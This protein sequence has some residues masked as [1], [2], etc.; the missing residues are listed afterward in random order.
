MTRPRLRRDDG[1]AGVAAWLVAVAVWLAAAALLVSP[2][3]AWAGGSVCVVN[4]ARGAGPGT[5]SQY[6]IGAIGELSPLSPATVAAGGEPYGVAVSPDGTSV[7]VTIASSNTVSQYTVD[8]LTGALSPKTPA[9][10]AAGSALTTPH[11]I[12]VSPSGTSV[13]VTNRAGDFMPGTVSQY[14]VDPLSGTLS[15]KTPS[16]VAAGEQPDGVAVS[17]DGKN[18]YVTNENE[19]TVSQYTV[20]P[21]TGTLSE[22]TPASIALTPGGTADENPRGI[23]V[24]PNGTSVYVATLGGAVPQFTVDPVT[25]TLSEKT[26]VSAPHGGIGTGIDGGIAVSPDGKSVYVTE[27]QIGGGGVLQYTVDPLSGLLSLKTPL[28]VAAGNEPEGIAVSPDGTS[29]YVANFGFANGEGGNVSQYA[30]DPLTGALS[31]EAPATV[32][33]GTFPFGVAVGLLPLAAHP[34]AT[35]V[36]CVPTTVVAGQ[37]SS[38][39]TATVSDMAASGQSTPT[40]MVCFASTGPGSFSGGATCTLSQVSTGVASCSLTYTP[41]ATTST[42]VRSDTITATYNDDPRHAASGGSA[43][44]QVLSI[45]LPAGGSFALGNQ[46]AT[47]GSTVTFWA[48]QWSKLNLLSG[49]PAPV[50]FKGFAANTPNNPPRCGD[51]WTAGT[52][53][54][55][56]PPGSVPALMAVVASSSITQSNDATISGNTAKVVVVQTNPGY[57]P[58]PGHPGTGTVLAELCP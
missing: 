47:L 41:S 40:G 3:A 29:A 33:A 21:L 16:S 19:E 36:N 14:T 9:S 22:K 45:T 46:N 25:G 58:N 27:E 28:S 51:S 43:T 56:K 34:T 8:P 49:G 6:A 42:P 1:S 32:E 30:I 38:T 5:V 44:V 24:S 55:V 50:S 54:S 7:Y 15:P 17:P 57:A 10:V 4:D 26:P 20:D 2:E 39:C 52:G 23:V 31:P 48:A 37:Q 18:V 53:N 13:Y 11:G 12:A 35:I